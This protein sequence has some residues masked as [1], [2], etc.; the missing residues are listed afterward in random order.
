MVFIV[1]TFIFHVY[2]GCL[3]LKM[4]NLHVDL[5]CVFLIQGNSFDIGGAHYRHSLHSEGKFKF[6]LVTVF[7]VMIIYSSSVGVFYIPQLLA[8]TSE[9]PCNLCD[10]AVSAC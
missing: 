2:L 8:F 9:K 7:L 6:T 10:L 4:T 1:A 5:C 3:C